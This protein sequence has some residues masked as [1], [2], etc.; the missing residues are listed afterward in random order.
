MNR[1]EWFTLPRRKRILKKRKEKKG[2]IKFLRYYII[3]IQ[4]V[5]FPS[6]NFISLY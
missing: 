6:N 4:Y 3:D 2:E 5:E 1:W